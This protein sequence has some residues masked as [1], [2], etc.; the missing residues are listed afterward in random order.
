MSNRIYLSPPHQTGDERRRLEEVLSLNWL[1]PAGPHLD[2]LERAAAHATGRAG[3]AAVSSGTA[4]LH[5]ALIDAGVGPGDEVLCSTLTFCA[6]A[7]PIRYQGAQPVFIDADPKTWNLDPQLVEDELR[8][9]ASRGRRPKAIVA[10]DLFGQSADLDPL[11]RLAAEFEVPLISD[12]AESLGAEYQGRPA[13]SGGWASVLSLNGNKIITAGG[14]GLLCSDDLELLERTRFRATQS[15]DPAPHYQHSELGYNYRLSNVLAAIG[16]AQFSALRARVA[17]RRAHFSRYRAVLSKLPG[18]SLM[19]QA[20]Y[21]RSN[22][23]LTV[24]QVDA[25]Q[26]GADRERIRQALEAE[27]IESRPVWKPLHQQPLFAGCRRRGGEVAERLF[28]RGLCLP[29][30]SALSEPQRERVVQVVVDCRQRAR[31]A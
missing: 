2:E 1:A 12:A 22:C 30:G 20:D 11:E 10:V 7:N 3:A 17:A 24:I 27:N 18:I 4:A 28:E 5:L 23:W 19:P 25:N 9:M 8:E 15:R 16:A 6:S 31:A 14:G 21:G 13:G 26:F 29:S